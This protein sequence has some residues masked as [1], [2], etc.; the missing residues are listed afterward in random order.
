MHQVVHKQCVASRMLPTML[1][2]LI[3]LFVVPLV[4]LHR[5]KEWMT[6]FIGGSVLLGIAP[7]LALINVDLQR[8]GL[9]ATIVLASVSGFVIS[10]PGG[11]FY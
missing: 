3:T 1:V 7:T 4:P 8:I 11:Y 6:V 5:R 2:P 10:I 9:A